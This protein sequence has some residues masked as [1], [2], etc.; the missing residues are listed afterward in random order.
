V[1]ITRSVYQVPYPPPQHNAPKVNL[2][3]GA[4]KVLGEL[5]DGSFSEVL[6][7]ERRTDGARYALKVM[8]KKFIIREKKA[9]FVKNERTAMDRC[10]D[11]PGVV[12]LH[13]TF[14]AGPSTRPFFGPT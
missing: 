5:G 10:A 6:H 13:F 11:V 9:E 7:V 14:Q 2:S 12:R 4:F 3:M 1:S 8:N